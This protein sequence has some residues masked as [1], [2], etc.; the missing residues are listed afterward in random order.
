[1]PAYEILKTSPFS[2]SDASLA[3]VRETLEGMSEEEKIGQLFHLVTYTSDEEALRALCETYH[4]GGMMARTLPLEEACAVSNALQRHSRIPMLISAN[5]EAGGDGMI[6]EGTNVGPN[7]LIA[8]TGDATAAG[9]Q[10]T[11]AAREG[12]AV[13]A[14][15]AFAPVIDIDYNFR[16]P[17]TNTRTYGSDPAFVAAAGEAFTRAVQAEG[18]AVSIKH[19]PGDGCDER[20]QHL[21]TSINSLSAEA[22]DA[23]YGTVWRRSIEAGALTVMVGHIMQPAYSRALVPD[24]RDEDILPASLAPELLGGLLR[25]RLGFNGMIITDSSTMAGMC[26]PMDRRE[27]VPRAIAAGCDMFLFTKNI[28]EDYSY[29]RAGLENGILTRERL[30]EAV[31][32]ILGVKAALHL[33]EQ[34]QDGSIFVDPDT[35]RKV[36]GCP[37]HRAIERDIADRGVTLVKDREGILP[38]SP[39]R[40]HRVLL[41]G[42]AGGENAFGTGGGED[43]EGLTAEALRREGFEVTVFRPARGFEGLMTP[44]ADTVDRY[45]LILYISNLATKSNQTTVRIEWASPMGANCPSYLSVVPTVFI[46]F[47]NP[48]H[49]LDV[50]RI[51]TFVN[52]YK[53]KSETLRAVVDKL[54]GRS[55]F[56]GASPVDATCGKWDARL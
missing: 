28:D 4:P 17:I 56:R 16:N 35:A 2:L 30:D 48:Y 39:S 25:G 53:F 55:P 1:M 22:W 5:F 7:M 32:R 26:I 33:P 3:W 44:Y 14:N 47:A 34:R 9:L 29:M 11:I 37:A 23:T 49:L 12:R 15:Y 27:A 20:D 54:L 13:G 31:M 36:V 38:L 24:I 6:A 8:A 40:H 52:A 19:F 10:G 51:K 41:I 50:P 43:I 46:S 18:M 21:V 42:L 45:D